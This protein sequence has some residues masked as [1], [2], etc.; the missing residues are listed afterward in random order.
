MTRH[1]CWP[2]STGQLESEPNRVTPRPKLNQTTTRVGV[3]TI[4]T[5]LQQSNK[6]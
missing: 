5:S 6:I 2:A 4:V 3:T 1:N